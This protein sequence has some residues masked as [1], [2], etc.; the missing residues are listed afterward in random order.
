MKMKIVIDI[1]NDATVGDILQ[2]IF[3]Q[4]KVLK[5]GTLVELVTEQGIPKLGLND[6]FW[7][8]IYMKE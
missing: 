2:I 3:P 4:F 5:M 6:D 7:D 1:R 8:A